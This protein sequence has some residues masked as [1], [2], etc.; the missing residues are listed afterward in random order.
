MV[1]FRKIALIF[2]KQMENLT[3]DFLYNIYSI[4]ANKIKV[5]QAYFSFFMQD[6]NKFKKT[7]GWFL[8][9]IW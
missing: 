1:N 4:D 6:D 9:K 8:K 3:I 2:D 5:V 7:K